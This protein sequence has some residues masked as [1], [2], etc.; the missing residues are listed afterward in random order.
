MSEPITIILITYASSKERTSY[1]IKTIDSV[2]DNIRYPN[3]AWFVADDGSS[4]EHV[5]EVTTRLSDHNLIGVWSQRDSYGRSANEGIAAARTQGQLAFFLED[6][7]EL[8]HPLD[9][10]PYAALL[11]EDESVGMIRMGYLNEGVKGKTFGHRGQLYWRLD[12]ESPYIFAGHPSL[13]H[14]RFHDHAGV[15]TERL[16]PGETELA[17]AWKYKAS[18]DPKPSIMWPCMLGQNGPFAHIGTVQSYIWNG[19]HSL[20]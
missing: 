19:G 1:A 9:L 5:S 13:R 18:P 8:N 4:A 10:W 16:Q 6:D 3:L 11:M 20:S 12:D 17:M 7:W 2:L 15:Y 14:L